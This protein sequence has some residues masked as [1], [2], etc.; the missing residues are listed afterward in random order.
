M[1]ERTGIPSPRSG[2]GQVFQNDPDK[3]RLYRA[4]RKGNGN[5]KEFLFALL[6]LII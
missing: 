3:A 5:D 2:R 1:T 4:G 6:I